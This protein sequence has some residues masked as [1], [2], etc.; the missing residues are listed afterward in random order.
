MKA[1]LFFPDRDLDPEQLLTRREREANART[2]SPAL[3]LGAVLPPN[4]AAL[5]QDLGLD[6]LVRV[7]AGDD[8][9]KQ[10]V[11]KVALLQS[12]ADPAIIGYRQRIMRDCLAH[13]DIV[14]DVYRIASDALEAS[15]K[16]FWTAFRPY[17]AGTLHS[18]ITVLTIFVDS[19]KQLRRLADQ[20]EGL[21]RSEGLRRLFAMVRSELSD[22]YF[23]DVEAHLRRLEFR[24]GMLMSARLGR[25]NKGIDYALRRQTREPSWFERLLPRRA[26]GY[27]FRLHPR[28]EAGAQALSQ[29][30]GQGVN[31]VANAAAQA[32]DHITA[33]FQMLRTELA[34]YIGAVHLHRRLKALGGPLCFPE[35]AE[36]GT[37][38]LAYD[39]LYDPA[40]A[41]SQG[42]KVI[43]NDH[44]ADGKDLVLITGA[45]TGGKSTFLRSLAL[46]Q[47]MM[48]AGM[49]VAAERFTSELRE[50]VFTHFRREEDTAME[51]GKLDEE[52]SRMSTLVDRLNPRAMV[53]LNESFS[54]TNEREG[55]EI[56]GQVTRA[57]LK[58][59]VRVAAVTHLYEFARAFHERR[60]SNMLFLRAE[61][62]PDGTRSFRLVEGGPL[63]TSYGKDL[64]QRIFC[65]GK[66][67]AVKAS[68]PSAASERE[69]CELADSGEATR[70]W[71]LPR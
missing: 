5:S 9:F 34:F 59:G 14:S 13:P 56:A 37:R 33:F 10:E 63:Q 41:L 6:I 40:L 24:D 19:L 16:N 17:P 11:A 50:G 18:A 53:F 48:Q 54:S 26:T 32:A 66:E 68:S 62:Q 57:L 22:A 65:D 31:L 46:A 42:K 12:S 60:A 7:M 55:S 1:F 2:P 52:L 64:Y 28:D 30:R 69:T 23:G 51:S 39:G 43:G 35:P 44:N 49:F 25:G 67:R 45:N 38:R 29:L 58:S 3:D 47:L 8:R 70:P 4:E 71:R 61:R 20:H 27:T 36:Y 15:R 21:F